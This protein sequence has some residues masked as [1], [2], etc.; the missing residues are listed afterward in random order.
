MSRINDEGFGTG[1]MNKS[2]MVERIREL[3]TL[4]KECVAGIVDYDHYEKAQAVIDR[5][6]EEEGTWKRVVRH[7]IGI[8]LLGDASKEDGYRICQNLINSFDR[9]GIG[10][11][12]N[13]AEFNIG[14]NEEEGSNCG[15]IAFDEATT[16]AE[17]IVKRWRKNSGKIAYYTDGL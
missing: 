5:A 7:N 11:W 3:E 15:N 17:R 2:Q 9:A 12:Y 16:K 6:E 10:A 4:I 8:S 13:K 14:W 1:N